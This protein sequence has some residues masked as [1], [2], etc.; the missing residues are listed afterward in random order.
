MQIQNGTTT[1]KLK[2]SELMAMALHASPDDAETQL[3]PVIDPTR[4]VRALISHSPAEFLSM[5]C[6]IL[7]ELAADL[8]KTNPPIQ[9]KEALLLF[10]GELGSISLEVRQFD[11]E[12]GGA[13]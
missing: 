8:I 10:A 5:R 2:A 11:A 7:S 13:N 4:P 12:V 9:I 1:T 3:L 6:A